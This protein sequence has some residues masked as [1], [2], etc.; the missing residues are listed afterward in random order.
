VRLDF[1][2]KNRLAA[3]FVSVFDAADVARIPHVLAAM[4]PL[5]RRRLAEGLGIGRD[6]DVDAMTAHLMESVFSPGRRGTD[7]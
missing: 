5:R 7:A 6:A 3:A 4:D 2:P 1:M